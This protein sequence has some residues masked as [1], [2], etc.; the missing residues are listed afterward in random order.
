MITRTIDQALANAERLRAELPHLI[1]PSH[2][3]L[4][5]VILADEIKALRKELAHALAENTK[6]WGWFNEIAQ[7]QRTMK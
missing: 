2:S 6:V 7:K 4:D 3:D 1:Q 5:M